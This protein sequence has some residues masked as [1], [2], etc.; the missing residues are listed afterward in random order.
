MFLEGMCLCGCGLLLFKVGVFY[1]VIGVG[2][3]IIFIVC[4]LIDKFKFNCW[5]N[6]YVIV[7]VLFFISIEGYSKENICELL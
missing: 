7:E 6:G 1:V 4:S 3:L 5:N 2:V